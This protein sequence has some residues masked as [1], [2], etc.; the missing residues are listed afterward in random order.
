MPLKLIGL[1]L[2]QSFLPPTYVLGF[3][4]KSLLPKN[5]ETK[6]ASIFGPKYAFNLN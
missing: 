2:V 1:R 6:L 4:A 3:L 5:P